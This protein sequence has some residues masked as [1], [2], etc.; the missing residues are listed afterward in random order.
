MTT[1]TAHPEDAASH[2]WSLA[3]DHERLGAATLAVRPA[4]PELQLATFLYDV[5]PRD[6]HELATDLTTA[7]EQGCRR[8]V[9][10]SRTPAWVEAML[11]LDGWSSEAEL[12]LELAAGETLEG[13]PGDVEVLQGAHV[14]PDWHRRGAMLRTDHLEEDARHGVPPR[15]IA[16]TEATIAHRAALEQYAPYLCAMHD[17]EVVGFLCTWVSPA[18]IGVIEDVFVDPAH[19]GRGL[20][21]T[22]LHRAVVDL[23]AR[24]ASTIGIAAEIGDAP[25]T[26]YARLGFAPH[27]VVRSCVLADP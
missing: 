27:H 19:R 5:Q 7:I 8:V 15:P 6:S 20:A 22:L 14:D 13:S 9:L 24:G 3:S 10:E 16:Q 17:G 1:S 25:A 21:T 4:A 12:R 11:L 23:R 26:L 18:G 2:L